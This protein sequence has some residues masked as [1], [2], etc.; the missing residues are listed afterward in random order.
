MWSSVCG[1]R[2][3]YE[4]GRKT[5]RVVSCQDPSSPDH[6]VKS[7][8]LPLVRTGKDWKT[9]DVPELRA[10]LKG[11]TVVPV[12]Q[13]SD[14]QAKKENQKSSTI[15]RPD[16]ISPK[17][18]TFYIKKGAPKKWAICRRLSPTNGLPGNAGNPRT[19]YQDSAGV[20]VWLHNPEAG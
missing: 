6:I 3:I 10:R 2:D 1:I 7:Q 14:A 4:E 16:H 18:A 13:E 9:Q 20:V 8:D 19:G 5:P 12:T 15:T 11:R 17:I